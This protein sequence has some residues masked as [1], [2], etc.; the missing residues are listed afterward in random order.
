M[1]APPY[2]EA[3]EKQTRAPR[4]N[5]YHVRTERGTSTYQIRRGAGDGAEV[6]AAVAVHYENN[7]TTVFCSNC[8]K[9][10]CAHALRVRERV[11]SGR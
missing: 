2:R 4:E 1:K 8:G 3:K 9:T 5:V 11:T 10:D 6:V 7:I